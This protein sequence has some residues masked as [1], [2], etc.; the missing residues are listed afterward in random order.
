MKIKINKKWELELP[1]HRK[2]QWASGEWEAKR[3][4]SM[5]KHIKK[6]MELLYVGAE[7]GDVPALCA[8]W[9]ANVTLVEPSKR[10]WPAIR[11]SFEMNNLEPVGMYAGFVGRANSSNHRDGYYNDWPD[12]SL[13]EAVFEPGFKELHEP[14]DD[15][16]E[17][18][19][20]TIDALGVKV[21]AISIDVE[22]SEFEV[23]RGA[24]ETLKRDRPLIWISVHPEF[25]F[26]I[27]E[28][29]QY[30]LRNWIKDI[31]YKETIIDYQHELHLLYEKEK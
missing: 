4:D 18:P 2:S 13:G 23:L 9:G 3:L 14:H 17:I 8:K 21:D 10:M 27:Y 26:R 6:D 1:D 28:E 11:Q 16:G 5:H 31:G 29:Y 19:Q 22:G 25:M 7:E 30:D 20:T 15:I 12:F 24:E